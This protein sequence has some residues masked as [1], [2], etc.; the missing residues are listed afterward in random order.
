MGTAP[1][2]PSPRVT[3]SLLPLS[4]CEGALG[5]AEWIPGPQVES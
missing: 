1:P 5:F 3:V 2:P 4:P